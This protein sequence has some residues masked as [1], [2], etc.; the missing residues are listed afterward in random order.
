MTIHKDWNID[1]VE[2]GKTYEGKRVVGAIF[3]NGLNDIEPDGSFV[4]CDLGLDTINDGV[5]T[6]QVK[7]GRYGELRFT[8]SASSNKHLC[9][10]KYKNGRGLSFKYLGGDSGLPDVSNGRPS[11]VSDDGVMI[12]HLPTYKGVKIEIVIDDPLSA[13]YKYPFSVKTYGQNYTFIEQDGGIVARGEDLVPILIHAPYAI[14]ANGDVGSVTMTLTGVVGGLQEFKKTV[15]ESWLRQAV[16]PI[17]ID[18]NVTIDDVSGIFE[19]AL[20]ASSIPN[21]NLGANAQCDTLNFVSPI[22]STLM[23]VDL[24]AYSDI[25][26]TSSHFGLDVFSGT[27]PLDTNMHK[28]LVPWGEG[29]KTNAAATAGECSYNHSAQP[30]TWNTAG[31]KGDGSD[32]EAT[33]IG[34]LQFTGI[35]NDTQYT[36]SNVAAQGWVDVPASNY[37]G[38]LETSSP[39]GSRLAVWRSS[40]AGSGNLP[41]FYMEFTEDGVNISNQYYRRLMSGGS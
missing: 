23:Y 7:R 8:D 38:L 10:I 33:P 26:I 18:P 25:T 30:T 19:D 9:K 34:S 17:R 13:P 2:T 36:I 5:T 14:D 20:I 4:P 28:V 11:F 37:G 15:D 16:A 40:E 22:E 41:Y 24:S 32:R 27:F 21:N 39:T 35:N 29:N 1:E 12:E 3:Q 31:C 6:H